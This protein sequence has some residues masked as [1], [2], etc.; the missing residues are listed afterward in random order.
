MGFVLRFMSLFSTNKRR[1]FY[2]KNYPLWGGLTNMNLNRLPVEPAASELL[3]RT[4]ACL[5]PEIFAVRERFVAAAHGLD[6]P[7]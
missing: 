2:P 1:R 3:Y 4:V 7:V 6:A 5:R